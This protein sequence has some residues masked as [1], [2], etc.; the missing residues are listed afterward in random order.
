MLKYLRLDAVFPISRF[1]LLITGLL[2]ERIYKLMSCPELAQF[3]RLNV[4]LTQTRS[5]NLF[6]LLKATTKIL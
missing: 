1:P 6:E 3:I 2:Q 4:P 5:H